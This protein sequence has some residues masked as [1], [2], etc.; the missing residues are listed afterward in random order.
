[1]NLTDTNQVLEIDEHN[2]KLLET[3]QNAHHLGQSTGIKGEAD[4]MPAPS[5]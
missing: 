3:A 4:I 5:T 1:M 2:D